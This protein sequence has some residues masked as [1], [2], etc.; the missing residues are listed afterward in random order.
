VVEAV[1]RVAQRLCVPMARVALAW[2]LRQPEVSAPI[3]GVTRLEQLE[4][5]AAALSLTLSQQDVA[6]LEADYVPHPVAGFS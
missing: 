6:E 1:Q 4:E 2:V 3:I 5:A